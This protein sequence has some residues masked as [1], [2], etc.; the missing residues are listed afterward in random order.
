MTDI[1][2]LPR[3]QKGMLEKIIYCA[4]TEQLPPTFEELAGMLELKSKINARRVVMELQEKGLVSVTKRNGRIVG[5]SVKPTS[6]V[7]EWR[8]LQKG[9]RPEVTQHDVGERAVAAAE[10][11]DSEVAGEKRGDD[12]FSIGEV[13]AGLFRLAEEDTSENISLR[14]LFRGRSLYMLKVTGNSMIGDHIVEGDYVI[15]DSDAECTDGEM[16]VIFVRGEATVKRLR[17]QDDGFLLEPSNP[18]YEPIPVERSD[19]PILLGKIIGVVRDQI[20]RRYR[21]PADHYPGGQEN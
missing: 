14:S 12:L 8:R 5:R 9:E 19:Q 11:T 3:T 1:D 17:R 16:V 20:K 15:V 6:V 10:E 13:P 2:K 4:E 21:L 18:R 7:W